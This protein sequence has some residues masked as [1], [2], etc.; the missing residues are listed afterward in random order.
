MTVAFRNNNL[1]IPQSVNGL[2]LAK[3]ILLNSRAEQSKVFRANVD[4]RV[5]ETSESRIDVTQFSNVNLLLNTTTCV[6]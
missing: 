2:S 6:L 3:P 4:G 5:T 1:N